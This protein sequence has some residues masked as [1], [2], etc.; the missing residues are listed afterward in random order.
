MPLPASVI[1][2]FGLN[3]GGK[4][5]D[6]AFVLKDEP[7]FIFSDPIA[8]FVSVPKVEIAVRQRRQRVG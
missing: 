5:Q 4:V 2:G 6:G 8:N 3:A 1:L 7:L